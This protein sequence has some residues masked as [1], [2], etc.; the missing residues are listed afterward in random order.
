MTKNNQPESADSNKQTGQGGYLSNLFEQIFMQSNIS[1]QVLDKDGWCI[2][3][4]PK[5]GELFGVKAEDIEGRKYNIFK[6][7]GVIQG[8]VIPH[9]N[10]VFKEG[11]PATWEVYFDIGVASDSQKIPVKKKIKK[12]FRNWAFPIF[13]DEGVLTNVI[14]Q[15]TDITKE[16]EAMESLKNSDR[17]F[18]HSI[19]MLAIAGFDGYFKVLNPSWSKMLGYSDQELK[20]KPWID[21]V[22]PD[23]REATRVVG[24]SLQK[25]TNIYGFQNRYICKDGSVKWL[26]WNSHPYSDEG[27]IFSVARDITELKK[28]EKEL[29]ESQ[30]MLR[31]VIDTIP[32]RVFWKDVDLCYLGC[33]MPFARD[34]GHNDPAELIGK[35]DYAMAWQDQ[36]ELYR[37]DDRKVI[38]SGMPKLNY[39]EPQTTP[40]GKTIWLKTSKIPLKNSKGEII[41]VLGTYEDVTEAKRSAMI[42]KTLYGIASAAISTTTMEDLIAEIRVQLSTII[43]TSNFYIALYDEDTGMLHI[44]YEEDEKDDIY[45]WSAE[46][47]AT[48]LAIKQKKS[49]L[50]TKKD[51]FN[52]VKEGVI[53]LVGTPSEVWLGVPLFDAGKVIGAIAMQ[54]YDDPNAFDTTTMKMLEFIS[55][56]VSM[57][58]QRNKIIEEMTRARDKARESDRLKTAFL[59]NLSHEIRT[60]LNAIVG[61]SQFLKEPDIDTER[62]DHITDVICRSSDQLLA[63]ISDIISISSIEAGIM[64]LQVRKTNINQILEN[65][66]SSLQPKASAKGIEL[67]YRTTLSEQEANVLADETKLNQVLHNL[68]DNAIKFTH[69]GVVEFGCSLKGELCRFFVN[70]TGVGIREDLHKVIFERFRQID[71][72]EI[73]NMGG[74]GLGLP[75]A[76]HFVE[77]MNGQMW[78]ESSPGKGS[79]FSFT[80]PYQPA[81]PTERPVGVKEKTVVQGKKRILVAEDEENNFELTKAIL[82]MLGMEVVHAWNG[83]EAVNICENNHDIAL[84]LMDIKMPVMDGYEATQLIKQKRPELPIIALTAY[85]LIGDREKALQAGCDDYLAKPV[86]IDHFLKMVH[87]Y[88]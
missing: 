61:F 13:N 24:E 65:V 67:H 75:I 7:E 12:W 1:T 3:I 50:L 83:Q 85:A 88:M 54:S 14:I 64:E 68:I 37:A 59:N 36:A 33:N 44:P 45:T 20:S 4:N 81:D 47:S 79:R 71:A 17:V 72:G 2:R 30:Q 38:E 8:D 69:K 42:Q 84:V 5:L 6:D 25:G 9:L 53:D 27:V 31:L 80:I 21:M 39:E 22:H 19:D 15:H 10:Q 76:K 40:E 55:G 86:S 57:A 18:K 56:Q 82:N 77:L 26:S 48:G 87:T 41:G 28:A 58:I 60:P 46:R 66:S 62:I 43:E 11:K 52:L 63:I 29:L 23:D 74:L 32:V 49:L 34:A 51:V 70:D 35:D 16:K 78:I 73:A